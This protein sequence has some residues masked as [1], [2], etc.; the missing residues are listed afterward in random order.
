MKYLVYH[1]AAANPVRTYPPEL[2]AKFLNLFHREFR[3]WIIKIVGRND[4][5]NR[6]EPGNNIN[7]EEVLK[8]HL[9]IGPWIECPETKNFNELKPIIRNAGLVVCPDSSISHLVAAYPEV[10]AISLWGPFHP[11]DRAK[12]YTNHT[13]LFG[14]G[15]DHA[16]CRCHD[17]QLPIN[18]CRLGGDGPWLMAGDKTLGWCNALGSIQPETI[19]ATAKSILDSA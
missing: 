10:P 4:R 13:K 3:E 8:Q 19:L 1:M 11:D 9:E 15:C 7:E 2:G 17:F 14:S 16:P 6:L 18:K 5:V 12:Y